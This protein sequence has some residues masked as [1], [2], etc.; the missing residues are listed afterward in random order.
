MF[1]VGDRVVVVGESSYSHAKVG[2]CGVIR[3][4][5][6]DE[7]IYLFQAGESFAGGWGSDERWQWVYSSSL[8]HESLASILRRSASTTVRAKK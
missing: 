2:T 8:Q 1:K 6:S 3:Q 4:V 5:T 7:P